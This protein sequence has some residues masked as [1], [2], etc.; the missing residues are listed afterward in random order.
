VVS[1]CPTEKDEAALSLLVRAV[2]ARLATQPVEVQLAR[3]QR[4]LEGRARLRALRE[5]LDADP[6]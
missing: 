1:R 5:R 4:Q 3:Q 6:A 2:E